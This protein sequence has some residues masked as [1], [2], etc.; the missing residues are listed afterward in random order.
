MGV[1]QEEIVQLT[2]LQHS[3]HVIMMIVDWKMKKIFMILFRSNAV[4]TFMP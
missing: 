4:F 2:H 3:N 1:E